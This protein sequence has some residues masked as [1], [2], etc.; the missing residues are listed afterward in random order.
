MRCK[1]A[2]T[3]QEVELRVYANGKLC[4]EYD[5]IRASTT[6]SDTVECFIPVDLGDQLTIRGTHSASYLQGSFHVLA[7]GSF[8]GNKTNDYS[9]NGTIKVHNKAGVKFESLLSAPKEPSHTSELPAEKVIEGSLHVKDMDDDSETTSSSQEVAEIGVGSLAIVVSMSQQSEIT[10]TNDYKSI[11]CGERSMARDTVMTGG[12]PP[13]YECEFKI[14]N[15]NPSKR[16]QNLLKKHMRQDRFGDKPWATFI[17]YYRTHADT[18]HELEPY[19]GTF[20]QGAVEGKKSKG[21]ESKKDDEDAS[22]LF[23]GHASSRRSTP[24]PTTSTMSPPAPESSFATSPLQPSSGPLTPVRHDHYDFPTPCSSSKKK[25]MGQSFVLPATSTPT[26][27]IP[28][29]RDEGVSPFNA[30]SAKYNKELARM[31]AADSPTKSQLLKGRIVALSDRSGDELMETID[32]AQTFLSTQ[33]THPRAA[34]VA[35]MTSSTTNKDCDDVEGQVNVPYME[36]AMRHVE[37]EPLSPLKKA[38]TLENSNVPVSPPTLLKN[39]EDNNMRSSQS[40]S[41][42]RSQSA[43]DEEEVTCQV[44]VEDIQDRIPAEG[45]SI[46]AL[47]ES[48]GPVL[49]PQNKTA[50]RTFL[51][52]VKTA[53]TPRD[54]KY[55]LK[56]E[57]SFQKSSRPIL[58]PEKQSEAP[59]GTQ[60]SDIVNMVAATASDIVASG[61]AHSKPAKDETRADSPEKVE[62]VQSSIPAKW[63]ADSMATSRELTPNPKRGCPGID[64]AKTV[65]M[66]R[67]LEDNRKRKTISQEAFGKQEDAKEEAVRLLE[68]AKERRHAMLQQ[69]LDR[70]DAEYEEM[71]QR[72]EKLAEAE[73]EAVT[74]SQK[75][76]DAIRAGSME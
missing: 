42:A 52:L 10:Y 9:K 51:N 53:A 64:D 2:N 18:V 22:S 12:I 16:T 7:D 33:F 20:V 40:S 71:E 38:H 34:P 46:A 11:T 76:E 45:I 31:H 21:K 39:R 68:D 27:G 75:I 13:T 5:L 56:T 58:S 14:T 26:L 74:A 48:F 57:S 3:D 70:D 55:F 63:S 49:V 15:D 72:R 35:H 36:G 28:L 44:T 37:G 54:G 23:L 47:R 41:R 69:Q 6:G 24:V 29:G 25:L 50:A 62:H 19:I 43:E 1:K 17:F 60:G 30:D 66:L 67:K 65:Q 8:V 4:D 61:R 59:T 73:R 32:D